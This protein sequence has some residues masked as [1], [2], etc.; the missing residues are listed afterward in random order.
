MNSLLVQLEQKERLLYF[1]G[2][3]MCFG[4]LLFTWVGVNTMI[5]LFAQI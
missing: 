4:T 5:H 3:G 1:S 2:S